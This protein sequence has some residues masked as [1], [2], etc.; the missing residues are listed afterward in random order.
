MNL[1][2]ITT[3]S[4]KRID[5]QACAIECGKQLSVA[6]ICILLS[7]LF[8]DLSMFME[9]IPGQANWYL[10]AGWH[11][12]IFLLL[13]YRFW[14]T[15]WVALRL[16]TAYII[17]RN[18]GVFDFELFY[19]LERQ[20]FI[21]LSMFAYRY[22]CGVPSL[23]SVKGVVCLFGLAAFIDIFNWLLFIEAFEFEHNI[24]GDEW[25]IHQLSMALGDFIGQLLIIPPIL[26][27]HWFIKNTQRI[28]KTDTIRGLTALISISAVSLFV[29]WQRPDTYYLVRLLAFIPVAWMAYRFGWLGGVSA[30]ITANT[31]ITIEVAITG[32]PQNTIESQVYVIT[33][34]LTALILGAAVTELREA[35]AAL[36]LNNNKLQHSL[37]KNSQLA[38]RIV[39]VQETERKYLSQELHDE[40]GQSIT[41]LKLELKVIQHMLLEK[42][43]DAML[44]GLND[45][46]NAI[47]E[48]VYQLMHW[49][50]PRVLDDLG[51]EET[52]TGSTFKQNLS[53]ANIEYVASVDKGI[54]KLPDA[55][56]IAIYRI[57]QE[58]IT[59]SLKHSNATT[60]H[61]SVEINEASV[62][63][64]LRDN[65]STKI[66]EASPNEYKSSSAEK[67]I[68]KSGFGLQGIEERV[69]SLKGEIVILT[70]HG[71]KINIKLPLN[72][73]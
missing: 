56:Q 61:L 6:V 72:Y 17:S 37:N 15:L 2:N 31:L 44:K 49:L 48:S 18:T 67:V 36:L 40:V 9:I 33:V 3:L 46:A 70:E 39:D 53:K 28:N 21:F 43:P 13:P 73:L 41:A 47:Y 19:G 5:S 7:V 51:L 35:N 63:V 71:Y 54:N 59:N 60:F 1:H 65:G 57:C 11:L 62:N 32:V 29:F 38:A 8:F 10:N 64:S 42:A 24:T 27:I 50:R 52:L 4:P 69:Q 25:L 30:M 26:L 12:I 34:S 66:N 16:Y 45:N 55:F 14:I 58:A 20:F 23:T 22:F 68:G